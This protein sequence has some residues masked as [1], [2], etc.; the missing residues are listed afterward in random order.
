MSD[1]GGKNINPQH[2]RILRDLI[3]AG[4]G[5]Q[6]LSTELDELPFRITSYVENFVSSTGYQKEIVE[7]V[8]FSIV[9]GLG[10]NLDDIN[11]KVI[12]EKL[13]REKKLRTIGYVI[14]YIFIAAAV[15]FAIWL[16]YKL[17]TFI[18]AFIVSN[19]WWIL[20]VVILILFLLHKIGE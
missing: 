6:L 8:L 2:K 1:Y 12:D 11:K 10:V 14:L 19:W 18:I 7:E 16:L 15:C 17:V 3:K 13:A 5:N 4:Y 20:A 9:E